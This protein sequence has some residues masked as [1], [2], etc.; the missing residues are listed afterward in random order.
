MVISLHLVVPNC[1]SLLS[2]TL[3]DIEW[4]TVLDLKDAFFC[5]S[6]HPDSQ[7]L[8]AFE[9]PGDQDTKLT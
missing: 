6:L 2:Q 7:L 5:V 3:E 4:F 9:Y 1:Y 8:V